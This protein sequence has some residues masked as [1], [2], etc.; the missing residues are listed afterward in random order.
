MHYKKTKNYKTK[1]GKA[2]TYRILIVVVCTITISLTP[3]ESLKHIKRTLKRANTYHTASKEKK[4]QDTFTLTPSTFF[5]KLPYLSRQCCQY[6][7]PQEIKQYI[8]RLLY[9]SE[10]EKLLNSEI[11]GKNW[12]KFKLNRL[13]YHYLNSQQLAIIQ[14]YLISTPHHLPSQ[15]SYKFFIKNMP[16]PIKECLAK[17]L[18]NEILVF[19]KTAAQADFGL[20]T[21]ALAPKNDSFGLTNRPIFSE[22]TKKK[23]SKKTKNY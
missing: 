9:A 5:K 13:Y 12:Q 23:I 19:S 17:E 22:Q 2:M 20:Y 18:S 11:F 15:K 1:L 14:Y 6:N 7:I 16:F 8:Q 10:N 21:I 3:M 4:K